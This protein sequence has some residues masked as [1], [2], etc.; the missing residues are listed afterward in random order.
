MLIKLLLSHERMNGVSTWD[1]TCML[2]SSSN[3]TH[4]IRVWSVV[5]LEA[6]SRT[7]KIIRS[8]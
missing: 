1:L 6:F 2:L 7:K 3:C 5:S 8:V 4:V